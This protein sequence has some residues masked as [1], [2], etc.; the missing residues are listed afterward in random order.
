MTADRTLATRLDEQARTAHAASLEH[1]SA[2]VQAQLVQRRR[3]AAA[4]RVAA[5][6]PAW[7]WATGAMASLAL[8]LAVQLRAPEGGAP[9][10]ARGAGPAPVALAALD[11]AATADALL[12]EDPELYLWLASNEGGPYVE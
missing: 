8:V 1:L 2:R 4:P 11:P 12:T 5:R 9:A 6:R 3:A 7:P 10:T